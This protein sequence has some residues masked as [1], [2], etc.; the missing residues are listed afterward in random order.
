MII[1]TKNGNEV[2]KTSSYQDEMYDEMYEVSEGYHLMS[3]G[4]RNNDI[5][6][7]NDILYI[8]EHIVYEGGDR[9]FNPKNVGGRVPSLYVIRTFNGKYWEFE[10]GLDL[11]LV[12]SR[13]PQYAPMW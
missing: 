9:M 2:F 8:G 12:Y 7:D 4:Y 5:T 3:D 10:C 11:F 13:N 6:L 1:K